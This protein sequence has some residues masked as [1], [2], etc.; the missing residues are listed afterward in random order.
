[1]I[2]FK[3]YSPLSTR[4]KVSKIS[5]S[6]NIQATSNLQVALGQDKIL[7]EFD[8]QPDRTI[9]VSVILLKIFS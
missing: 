9:R 4:T 3:N 1:M 8:I 5:H 7:D 6:L 2:N